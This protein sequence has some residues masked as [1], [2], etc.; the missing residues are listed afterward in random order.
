M[1]P[2]VSPLC[3]PL[4][5]RRSTTRLARAMAGTLKPGDLLV[6]VGDLGAGKTFLT[7]ALCRCLGVSEDI[8]ITSPTFTLVNEHSGEWPIVHVDL[9]RVGSAAEAEDLGL[10]ERRIDAV[11]VVEWGAPY[12]SALG[13]DALVIEIL[14]PAAGRRARITATG[15]RSDAQLGMLQVVT[16]DL[17]GAVTP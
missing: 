2:D 7:R 1:G 12:V 15:A 3:V 5:T 8:A 13:G 10:R 17:R 6:L 9:Y 4:P 14:Q 11:M 16:A